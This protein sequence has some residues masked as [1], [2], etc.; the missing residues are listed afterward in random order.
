MLKLKVTRPI[1]NRIFSHHLKKNK[2][3]L[4]IIKAQKS[5]KNLI[6]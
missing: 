1:K 5:K 3:E 2:L 4:R 6:G